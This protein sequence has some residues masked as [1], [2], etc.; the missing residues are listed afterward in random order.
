MY[1]LVM[2]SCFK[3]HGDSFLE[4]RLYTRVLRREANSVTK[5]S[6]MAVNYEYCIYSSIMKFDELKALTERKKIVKILK[7]HRYGS[8]TRN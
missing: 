1:S 4:G 2:N 3:F 5:R 7:K 6:S 8:F